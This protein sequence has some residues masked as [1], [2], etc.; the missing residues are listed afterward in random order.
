[1]SLSLRQRIALE[2][3]R[4]LTKEDIREHRLQAVFWES[5]LRC[6]LHCRHCG[7]DCKAAAAAPDMPFKDFSKVLES[8]SERY[9]PHTVLVIVSGGEPL[10]RRDLEYCGEQMYLMG[11]PWGL[12]TNGYALTLERFRNMVGSGLRAISVSIDGLEEDHDWMR[13]RQTSF[14][15]ASDAIRMICEHNASVPEQFRLGFD[16]ITCVNARNI[17][18]LE[19]LKEHLISLGADAWRLFTIVP[20]GRAK[21][22]PELQL[23]G[24]Q[25]RQVMDFIVRTRKEGRIRCNYACEGFLG[26]YEGIARDR[27]FMCDA[28]VSVGSVL[29]DGSISACT[30]IRSDYHQGNIYK[31]D[32]I[33]VWEN[34]FQQYRDHGWMKT[35]ECASCRYWRYCRGSGMHLRNSDGSLIQCNLR[36]MEE[37]VRH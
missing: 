12:V 32:F 6:N 8:I 22:D 30:S 25:V 21:D 9:D 20:M 28:G 4:S 19:E 24:E 33:D 2:I 10:M 5:T 31:D 27:L 23:T 37:A 29:I 11:F 26:E 14:R 36:K 15:R 17:S 35:G 18:R 7:S 1:M 34:R 13:G 16:A 3:N